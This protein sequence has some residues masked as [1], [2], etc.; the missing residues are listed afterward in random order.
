MSSHVCSLILI[1]AGER[2]VGVRGREEV[3]R[4]AKSSHVCSVLVRV[5][6][7]SSVEHAL[8][9]IRSQPLSSF[10]CC[11]VNL[12]GKCNTHQCSDAEADW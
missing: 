8:I 9:D 10:N 4:A 5:T 7:S 6:E 3:K 2:Y 1:E 11:V 12:S